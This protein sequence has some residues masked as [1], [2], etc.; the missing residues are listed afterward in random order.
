MINHPACQARDPTGCS[1]CNLAYNCAQK[2]EGSGWAWPA[3]ALA[4]LA[5]MALINYLA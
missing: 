1:T 5:A 3:M 2:R 4:V